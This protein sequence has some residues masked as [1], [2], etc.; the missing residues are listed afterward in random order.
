MTK[1]EREAVKPLKGVYVL[2]IQV[3]KEAVL[4]VGALGTLTFKPGLY[5]YVGSAQAN[6]EQRVKRH[7]KKEKRLFWHIDYLLDNDAAKVVK[8]LHK[9]AGKSEECTVAKALSEKGE[10]VDDFGCSDCDCRSHLFHIGDY[11]FLL[12]SMQVLSGLS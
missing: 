10:P 9:K 4:N 1:L 7:L 8:V 2:I 12:N 3:E 11:G 5:D 6:M